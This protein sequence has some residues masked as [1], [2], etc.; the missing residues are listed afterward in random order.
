MNFE[1]IVL[2]NYVQLYAV[3]DVLTLN[4]RMF[5]NDLKI[6]SSGYNFVYNKILACAKDR[7]KLACEGEGRVTL[8]SMVRKSLGISKQK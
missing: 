2:Y 7:P 8:I 3:P 6:H 4:I 5:C 1:E